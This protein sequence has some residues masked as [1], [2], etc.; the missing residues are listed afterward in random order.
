MNLT[1]WNPENLKYETFLRDTLSYLN[2]GIRFVVIN[3]DD[4]DLSDSGQNHLP[5][6]ISEAGLN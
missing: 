2:T 5:D 3:L 6:D 4:D 1:L